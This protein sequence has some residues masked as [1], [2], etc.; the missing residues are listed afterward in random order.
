MSSLR[1]GLKLDEKSA[2]LRR[3]RGCLRSARASGGQMSPAQSEWVPEIQPRRK[4][5]P[6]ILL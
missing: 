6:K 1:A 2:K 5:K 4:I 3:R